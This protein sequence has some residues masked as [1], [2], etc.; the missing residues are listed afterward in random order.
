[1]KIFA[2]ASCT[3]CSLKPLFLLICFTHDFTICC[4]HIW[5][6]ESMWHTNLITSHPNKGPI[7]LSP[8]SKLWWC[9]SGETLFSWPPKLSLTLPTKDSRCRK[10]YSLQQNNSIK[11]N[12]ITTSPPCLCS[13]WEHQRLLTWS[14]RPSTSSRRTASSWLSYSPAL[15]RNCSPN[16]TNHR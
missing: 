14:R 10:P 6:W 7:P 11:L 4:I 5:V 16:K 3:S 2:L 1:V 12:T 13:L 9:H 8:N 15:T